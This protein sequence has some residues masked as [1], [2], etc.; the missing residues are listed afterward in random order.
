MILFF[1]TLAFIG[2]SK[3]DQGVW[4]EAVKFHKE[5]KINEAIN[6]YEQIFNEHP[7][8][9]LAP[10][11]LFEIGKLY[12]S[13]AVK[14]MK[15]VDELNKAVE[16]YGKIFNEF[17][18]SEEA[19]KALF[20]KGFIQSEDLRDYAAAKGTFQNFI[21]KYPNN[22]MVP[23]AKVELENMGKTPEEILKMNAQVK[24]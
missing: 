6:S 9:P 17:P 12:Q 8:S 2:C 15:P 21:E 5:G 20:M 19:P 4:D 22:E 10:K 1:I 13:R 18:T 24:K 23:S 11:A 14:N 3:S 7:K 16:Y